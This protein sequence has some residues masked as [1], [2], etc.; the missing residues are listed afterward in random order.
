VTIE[1]YAVEGTFDPKI[2]PIAAQL[3]AAG[4]LRHDPDPLLRAVAAL[5]NQLRELRGTPA[6]AADNLLHISEGID[7]A[8]LNG[9]A[10]M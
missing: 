4:D 6:R 9:S 7:A 3:N 10:R 1:K 2:N 8:T 5:E